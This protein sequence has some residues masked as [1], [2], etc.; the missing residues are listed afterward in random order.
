MGCVE[1]SYNPKKIYQLNIKFPTLK[2]PIIPTN[3]FFKEFI[4]SVILREFPTG[5]NLEIPPK[6]YFIIK[7]QTPTPPITGAT[8]FWRNLFNNK[9]KKLYK[10]TKDNWC[11]WISF[12]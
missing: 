4:I 11:K 2:I 12:V 8:P 9:R 7:E 5:I 3:I 1:H 6:K 10:Y